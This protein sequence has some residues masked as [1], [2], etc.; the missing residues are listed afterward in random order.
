MS[1]GYAIIFPP[2]VVL[3]QPTLVGVVLTGG[4]TLNSNLNIVVNDG[5]FNFPVTIPSNTNYASFFYHNG[6]L[7]PAVISCTHTDA[8]T[9]NAIS[10][11]PANVNINVVEAFNL[12]ALPL[13]FDTDI[14]DPALVIPQGNVGYNS[15]IYYRGYNAQFVKE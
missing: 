13:L 7:G 1:L 15:S 14:A 6:T 11:N 2:T 4:F 9:S 5:D 12:P 8:G 10:T 3:N